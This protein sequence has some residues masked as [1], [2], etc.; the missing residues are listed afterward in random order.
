MQ[1]WKS[2]I[3]LVANTMEKRLGYYALMI[4]PMARCSPLPPWL[5][6]CKRLITVRMVPIQEWHHG[7]S[8][9]PANHSGSRHPLIFP[10]DEFIPGR[11]GHLVFGVFIL[12]QVDGFRAYETWGLGYAALFC[13]TVNLPFHHIIQP[14]FF[15]GGIQ[16]IIGPQVVQQFV[17]CKTLH[18]KPLLILETGRIPDTNAGVESF[19][20]RDVFISCAGYY[21]RNSG[22]YILPQN[23]PIFLLAFGNPC[24]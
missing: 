21:R 24:W 10:F 16:I 18:K 15:Y 20:N 6:G 11:C 19:G 5:S 14:P 3:S 2:E 17:V 13:N 1:L 8:V 12:P 23:R 7:Y 4:T 22:R 9:P